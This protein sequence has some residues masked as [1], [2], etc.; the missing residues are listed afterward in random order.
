MWQAC[1]VACHAAYL[2][3]S[4]SEGDHLTRAN[5]YIKKAREDRVAMAESLEAV[6]STEHWSK[7]EPS[8]FLATPCVYDLSNLII[9]HVAFIKQQP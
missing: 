5:M 3:G 2:Y 1:A 4:K 9:T 6:E 8:H 7:I